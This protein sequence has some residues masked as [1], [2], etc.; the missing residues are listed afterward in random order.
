MTLE[1]EVDF[2]HQRENAENTVLRLKGVIGVTNEIAVAP[3]VVD[4][5]ELREEIESALERRADRQAERLRIEVSDGEVDLF[6]RVHSWQE[7]R[8][9]LGSISHAPGVNSVRDHLRVDPYF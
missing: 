7:K 9:V 1:G 4:A 8:A 3:R 6:G 5:K 2:W